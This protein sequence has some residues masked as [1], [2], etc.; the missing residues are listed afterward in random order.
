[1]GEPDTTHQCVRNEDGYCEFIVPPF[2]LIP[3]NVQSFTTNMVK[4][5]IDVAENP[6]EYFSCESMYTS[7]LTNLKRNKHKQDIRSIIFGDASDSDI[8]VG[9]VSDI[10]KKNRLQCFVVMVSV[11]VVIAVLL[12]CFTWSQRK[13]N[14][15]YSNYN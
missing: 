2:S 7:F 10:L 15:T 3:N 5:A 6:C 9:I 14:Q 4:N 11:A 8:M 13:V 12:R 1:M